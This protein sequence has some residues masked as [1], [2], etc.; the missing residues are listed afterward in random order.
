M[1]ITYRVGDGAN[2]FLIYLDDKFKVI[3]TFKGSELSVRTTVNKQIPSGV[4]YIRCQSFSYADDLLSDDLIIKR[5]SNTYYLKDKE[6]NRKIQDVF[7]E[8]ADVKWGN[9]FV[10]DNIDILT[11][12]D[13]VDGYTN[14]T[15]GKLYNDLDGA[16]RSDYIPVEDVMSGIYLKTSYGL[17][18]SLFC[19]YDKD[20]KFIRSYTR[21]NTVGIFNGYLSSKELIKNGEEKFFIFNYYSYDGSPDENSF[22]CYVKKTESVV[23]L[24]ED[25]QESIDSQ[26]ECTAW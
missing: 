19:A 16:K 7:N 26:W 8:V 15:N 17:N 6:Y 22:K 11:V 3:E 25:M 4:K 13:L 12:S 24:L 9:L 1:T 14:Y 2:P 5:N 23:K 18:V 20:K 21:L 10:G